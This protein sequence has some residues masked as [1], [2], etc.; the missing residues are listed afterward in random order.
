MIIG[1]DLAK[2]GAFGLNLFTSQRHWPDRSIGS[3][4]FRISLL[5][6]AV[7]ALIRW[8]S[9]RSIPPRTTFTPVP[10]PKP[11]TNERRK[12][13]AE[14]TLKAI[15][16]GGYLNS[17]GLHVPLLSGEALYQKSSFISPCE[18][19]QCQNRHPDMVTEVINEDCINLSEKYVRLGHKTALINFASFKEPGGGFEEHGTSGQE[20]H[21]C[22]RSEM[23]GLMHYIT[24]FGADQVNKIFCFEMPGMAPGAMYTPD[25]CVF[26][27][28]QALDFTYL[29]ETFKIGIISSAAPSKPRLTPE[30]QYADSQIE[31]QVRQ[32]ITTQLQV[33]YDNGYDAIVLGA[34]GC[35]AFENPSERVARIYQEEISKFQGAFKRVGFAILDDSH[36]GNHN[37]KGNFVPFRDVFHPPP[38]IPSW[39]EL[40]NQGQQPRSTSSSHASQQPRSFHS[41]Q[42]CPPPKTHHPF[43][44]IHQ[45][46]Y[47]PIP[48]SIYTP[49]PPPST[50][51]PPKMDPVHHLY[52]VSLTRLA[53]KK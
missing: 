30:L 34:F 53:G 18:N 13:V 39:E 19:P 1:R 28:S 29:E 17:S 5:A 4:F 48:F 23:A 52:A 20:E 11:W 47:H 32:S 50:P 16:A 24:F 37:P 38:V 51:S 27:Q 8:A 49:P 46:H 22:Y 12:A 41:S 25:V 9:Q 36:R 43:H 14:D 2:L 3:A 10:P 45:H 26:R 44:V 15:E 35:G 31:K 7:F 6:C 33:A 40:I 42:A 21:I